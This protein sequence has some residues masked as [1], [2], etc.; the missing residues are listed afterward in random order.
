MIDLR[1]ANKPLDE[2]MIIEEGSLAGAM[3]PLLPAAFGVS[4]TSRRWAL[5]EGRVGGPSSF[6]TYILLAN[7]D[8]TADA[9][10]VA[11]FLRTSGAPVAK[12]L[13]VPAGGRLTITTGPGSM[14]PQLANESFGVM[15]S[16]DRPVFAERAM[17][18]NAGGVFWAAGSAATA[19]R[20]PFP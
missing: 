20:M 15:L 9:V 5:A 10:V 12:T 16:A 1:D 14:V 18:S 3:A 17:Y 6:Q 11:T 19:T 2:G 8:A 7:P 13:V 4:E